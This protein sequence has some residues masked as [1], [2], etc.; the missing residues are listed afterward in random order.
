M[1]VRR[2]GQGFRSKNDGAETLQVLIGCAL[3]AP[4]P[5]RWPALLKLSSFG[6]DIVLFHI[7]AAAVSTAK[8][9]IC[10]TYFLA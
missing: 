7:Y 8:V 1:R 2:G 6:A 5:F 3:A 10:S 4:S 9:P